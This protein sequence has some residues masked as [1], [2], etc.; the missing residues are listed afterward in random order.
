MMISTNFDERQ[1]T[2]LHGHPKTM[3]YVEVDVER[4]QRLPELEPRSGTSN[5]ENQLILID[6]IMIL[7]DISSEM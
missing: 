7:E 3:S 5:F 4:P 6:L 2:I 1:T